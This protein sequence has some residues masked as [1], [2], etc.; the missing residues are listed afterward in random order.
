MLGKVIAK[1]RV[2]GTP[3]RVECL[4][5][6]N[7]LA[8]QFYNRVANFVAVGFGRE[9]DDETGAFLRLRRWIAQGDEHGFQDNFVFSGIIEALPGTPAHLRIGIVPGKIEN[10]LLL[11]W[12]E[13]LI[14]KVMDIGFAQPC[15]RMAD[16][17][18]TRFLVEKVDGNGFTLG[19]DL[20]D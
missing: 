20:P 4:G 8:V 10:S 14:K 19:I 11:L 9:S 1:I 2:H 7:W 16:Q 18:E 13:I 5:A 6:Q 17:F 15:K 3:H 12:R